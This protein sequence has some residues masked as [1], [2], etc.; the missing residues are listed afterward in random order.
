M[1]QGPPYALLQAEAGL[2][3]YEDA[4]EDATHRLSVLVRVAA[5]L[6][7]QDRRPQAATESEKR[8]CRRYRQAP[9]P[10]V[11]DGVR[12]WRSGRFDRIMQGEFDVI[13]GG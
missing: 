4:T 6:P 9:S 3:V 7:G 5:D 8:I 2:H 13:Q 1:G 10:L 11:R 12:G